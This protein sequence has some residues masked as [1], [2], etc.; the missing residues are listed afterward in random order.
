[1]RVF[2][3]LLSTDLV[4]GRPTPAQLYT[5]LNTERGEE[6]GLLHVHIC[7]LLPDSLWSN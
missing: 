2:I 1:M 4:A 6:L 3:P 7:M 5:Q